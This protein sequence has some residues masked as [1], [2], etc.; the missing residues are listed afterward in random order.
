M[1]T[2]KVTWLATRVAGRFSARLAGI[3]AARLWFTPWPVPMSD[4]AQIKQAE[5]L[6][7]GDPTAFHV[8]G[9][10]IAAFT[11]G[12]GPTVLLVHG[13]GESAASLGG[14]V[15]PL[16]TAGYRVVGIDLPGHG[17]TSTRRTDIFELASAVW[18]VVNQLG[19]VHA[20]VA[21]SLG[22]Y[23]TIE[24]LGQGLLADSVV[25]IAPA[26]NVDHALERFSVLFQLSPKASSG[27]RSNIQRRFGVGVWARLDA[28]ALAKGFSVPALIIHDTDDPQVDLADSEMLADSWP[29]ARVFT[30]TGLGHSK[31]VRDPLVIQ[32]IERFLID[33]SGSCAPEVVRLYAEHPRSLPRRERAAV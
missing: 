21:H 19:G 27:L 31:I 13:W 29:D 7:E 6:T 24:A 9:Q 22:G 11:A 3:F 10:D 8:D 17:R 18:G 33:P 2:L 15:T 16:V 12:E 14:M 26:T 1:G 28:L 5:W 30:T 20:V 4:G 23:A 32:E 25:L